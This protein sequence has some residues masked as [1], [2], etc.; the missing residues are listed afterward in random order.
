MVHP[1]VLLCNRFLTSCFALQIFR[2]PPGGTFSAHFRL[3]RGSEFELNITDGSTANK[4]V[5]SRITDEYNGKTIKTVSSSVLE[6]S[7]LSKANS[8]ILTTLEFII[9]RDQGM[10]FISR[11]NKAIVYLFDL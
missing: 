7:V 2:A 3:I 1:S 4:T 11:Q 6:V 5:L 10:T 9:L 8:R